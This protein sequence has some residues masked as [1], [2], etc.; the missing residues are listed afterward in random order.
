ME[1]KYHLEL[2]VLGDM[3]PAGSGRRLR[4]GSMKTVNRIALVALAVFEIWLALT[5]FQLFLYVV[6]MTFLAFFVSRMITRRG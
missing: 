3:L 4:R 2:G 1:Q 5:F 6:S